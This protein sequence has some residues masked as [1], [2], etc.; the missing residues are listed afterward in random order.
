MPKPMTRVARTE[1]PSE[2]WDNRTALR[3]IDLYID[4]KSE[5][6]SFKMFPARFWQ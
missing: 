3:A 6:F 1:P 2:H 4:G 5:Y